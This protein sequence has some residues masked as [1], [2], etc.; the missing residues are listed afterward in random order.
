MAR[1]TLKGIKQVVSTTY[2]QAIE[3]GETEGYI[4]FVRTEDGGADVGDIYIGDRHYG[5]YD[6]KT[7]QQIR[8]TLGKKA[9]LD[10]NNLVVSEQLLVKTENLDND[11][12]VNCGLY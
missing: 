4:W 2:N 6:E 10:V 3:D 9:D 11:L 12:E 8:E 1:K 7:L 5:R